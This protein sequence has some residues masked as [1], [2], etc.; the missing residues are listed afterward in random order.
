VVDLHLRLHGKQDNFVFSSAHYVALCGGIGS[1]KTY[2]GAVR[3]LAAGMGRVGDRDIPAPNLGIVTAATYPMLRDATFRVFRDVAGDLIA[4][5]NRSEFRVT[6]VNGSEILFRSA[7]DPDGLRGPNASWWW[8][9]EAALYDAMTWKVMIGRLRQYGRQ[10]YAWLTTTPKGRN[11]LYREFV[12][13]GD[14]DYAVWRISTRSNPFLDRG[15]VDALREAYSGDFARQELEG[16]FVTHEGLVY[17]EFRR[18]RHTF[19]EAPPFAYTVAGVD[20]GYANPGVILIFG[21]DGDS[22]M[23]L[24][25]E[26]YQ[27]QRRV[28]DWATLARQLQEVYGVQTFYCDPSEPEYLRMFEAAGC[29]T[30]N[31]INDVLPGIQ[32]VKNRLATRG[33]GRPRLLVSVDAVNT[34]VEF[35]QYQWLEGREGLRDQP[36]KANDHAMDALRYAVMGVDEGTMMSYGEYI[37]AANPRAITGRY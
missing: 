26:E 10:G 33:D 19:T 14:P 24:I 28:E 36:R 32:A 2:A 6:L 8:G 11:W 3:A 30:E 29:Y 9:D 13:N 17:L 35:E 37:E 21:V 16:D 18:D 34:L 20:W 1:G 22:R 5:T 27:R 4:G 12:E 25:H 15:F 31:A 7:T 23:W